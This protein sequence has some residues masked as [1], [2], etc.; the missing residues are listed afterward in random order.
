MP[1]SSARNLPGRLLILV[2]ALASI[3][4]LLEGP[5]EASRPVATVEYR[6]TAGDSLWSIAETLT[7]DGADVRDSIDVIRRL[8]DLATSS[9][10]T[11]Q[12]LVVPAG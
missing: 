10:D 9:L 4:L 12:V 3:F 6:V 11:G 1:Q 5:S 8:N 2:M 7:T